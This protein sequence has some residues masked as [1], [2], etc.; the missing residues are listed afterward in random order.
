[1]LVYEATVMDSIAAVRRQTIQLHLA[2]HLICLA[3]TRILCGPSVRTP[4]SRSRGVRRP[5][6]TLLASPRASSFTSIDS[7]YNLDDS[8]NPGLARDQG[9]IAVG[10]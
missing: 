10:E 6:R 4:P 1:M 7:A 9:I 2:C 8:I 5:R 3:C